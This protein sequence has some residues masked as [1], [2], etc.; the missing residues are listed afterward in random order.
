LPTT[1]SSSSY[2]RRFTADYFAEPKRGYGAAVHDVFM[3]L[4]NAGFD[5]PFYP[6]RKLFGG[7]GSFGNGAAMRIAPAALYAYNEI[8]KLLDI[9]SQASRITHSNNLG[10]RGA[11]LQSL[12]VRQAL[13]LDS[14][15]KDFDENAFLDALINFL[16]EIE[17]TD[18]KDDFLKC[19]GA[20]EE[21]RRS[22]VKK[23]NVVKEFLKKPDLPSKEEIHKELGVHVAAIN[24][25]PTAIYCVL[26][27]RKPI[28][29]IDVRIQ[30]L[31]KYY[32]ISD[33]MSKS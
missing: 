8:P 25:V 10:I 9:T 2:F 30:I 17:K 18:A 15:N 21:F 7:Q 12:A 29:G 6:A 1:Y 5:D 28:P 23:L 22:Y 4:R 16:Q 32:F 14:T 13:L 27:A 11:T 3:G 33:R 19:D 26:A 20:E 31:I 24:S